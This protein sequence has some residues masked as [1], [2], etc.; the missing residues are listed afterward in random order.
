MTNPFEKNPSN[1]IPGRNNE[2]ITPPTPSAT[3]EAPNVGLLEEVLRDSRVHYV[4]SLKQVDFS[5]DGG[6]ILDASQ[7][8]NE[9]Q[10]GNFEPHKA[11][12]LTFDTY[13][14]TP[15]KEALQRDFSQQFPVSVRGVAL[16]LGET[17][18]LNQPNEILGITDIL[19]LGTERRERTGD[20]IPTLRYEANGQFPSRSQEWL[21]QSP[22]KLR[23][24]VDPSC[25][26]QIFPAVLVYGENQSLLGIYIVDYLDKK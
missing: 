13:V 8:Y 17:I 1:V 21:L 20:R 3:L 9:V 12:I 24:I 16:N 2:A 23:G 11:D 7:Y 10:T 14:M 5:A 19:K 4:P 18:N 26:H 22:P 25:E 6:P 15:L